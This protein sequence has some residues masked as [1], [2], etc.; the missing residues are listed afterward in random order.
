MPS[1]RAPIY[2]RFN[3]A[4]NA[5]LQARY[6]LGVQRDLLGGRL[7]K[8]LRR[9]SLAEQIERKK[10]FETFFREAPVLHPHASRITGVICGAWIEEIEDPLMRKI[11]YR[12][13]LLGELAKCR[14]MEKILRK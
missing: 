10:D 7:K 9:A 11:R 6:D 13:K 12:D 1:E 2:W 14:P 4:S 8:V 5:N 3:S